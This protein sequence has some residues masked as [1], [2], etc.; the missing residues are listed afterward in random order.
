MEISQAYERLCENGVLK[1]EYK[2]EERKGL[3]RAL[4]YPMAFKTEWIRLVLSRI[5]DGSLWLEDVP[6]KILK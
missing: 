4:G 5:H 1:E 2:I 3:T 6:I